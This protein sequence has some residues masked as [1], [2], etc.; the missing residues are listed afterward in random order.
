MAAYKITL[1]AAR[2]N[3]NLTQE[4]VAKML[5]KSN[6]TINNWEK[7]KVQIDIANFNELCRIYN[8]PPDAVILPKIS[9]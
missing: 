1:A 8:A 9:S 5:G 3:A 2:K 7:G 6:K 4:E